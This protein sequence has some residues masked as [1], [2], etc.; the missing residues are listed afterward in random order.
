MASQSSHGLMAPE[1]AMQNPLVVSA[2]AAAVGDALSAASV[3]GGNVAGVAISA[4]FAKRL[5]AAREVLLSELAAGEKT[6]NNSEVEESAAIVYRYLKAAREGAARLNLR[7]LAAV[8][9]GQV[10]GSTIVSDEFL[11]YADLLSS[12]RRD[13]IIL[14]GT[15]ERFAVEVRNEGSAPT[16]TNLP[17]KSACEHGMH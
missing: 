10:R 16:M 9:A 6:L 13:E 11:Y 1:L 12:L 8:F 7:L 3:P 2:V 17:T 5:T 14:L 15:L 4:I